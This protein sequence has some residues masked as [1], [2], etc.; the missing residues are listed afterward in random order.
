MGAQAKFWQHGEDMVENIP[1]N[2]LI[3]HPLSGVGEGINLH[4]N[5]IGCL[6]KLAHHNRHVLMDKGVLLEQ[7]G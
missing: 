6:L 2:R 1:L 7:R 5:T 4:R 3:V